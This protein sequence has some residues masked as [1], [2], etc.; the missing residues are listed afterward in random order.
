METKFWQAGF[1]ENGAF[2][3]II[4]IIIIKKLL[5]KLSECAWK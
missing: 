4:I 3:F 1:A 2:V 5:Q